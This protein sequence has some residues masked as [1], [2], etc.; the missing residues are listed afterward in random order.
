MLWIHTGKR[1]TKNGWEYGD[2]D[3]EL[4]ELAMHDR[5][6][7]DYKS[8]VAKKRFEDDL[9]RAKDAAMAKKRILGRRNQEAEACQGRPEYALPRGKCFGRFPSK[10]LL[11]LLSSDASTSMMRCSATSLRRGANTRRYGPDLPDVW[12]RYVH[13]KVR[14]Y[15]REM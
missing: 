7:R 10:V 1:W 2:D 12:W 6:Y 14:L 15:I 8:G 3:E 13:S 4:F 5:Q 9:Q 11:L